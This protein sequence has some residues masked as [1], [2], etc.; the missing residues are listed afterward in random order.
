MTVFQNGGALS[1]NRRKRYADRVQPHV[2]DAIEQAVG[3]SMRGEPLDEDEEHWDPPVRQSRLVLH[4]EIHF[5]A[6]ICAHLAAHGWLH[7]EG[8]P[9]CKGFSP[10]SRP[11]S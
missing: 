1:I 9:P 4:R 8:A 10:R 6:E 3:R 11:G 7:A 5:E 2:L